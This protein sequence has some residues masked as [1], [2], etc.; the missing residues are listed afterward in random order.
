M[1]YSLNEYIISEVLV[2]NKIRGEMKIR[3]L[4][5]MLLLL[6]LVTGTVSSC[7]P[8]EQTLQIDNETSG[9]STIVNPESSALGNAN[10]S[11]LEFTDGTGK[12]IILESEPDRIVVAGKAT[13]YVLDSVYLFPSA[14]EKLVALE[15]RGFDTQAFLELVDPQVN[16]KPFLERDSGP[17]QIAPQK[18]DLVIVKDVSLAKLGSAL[19]EIGIPV[20]GVN[21]ETPDDFYKDLKA[22]GIVFNDTKRAD[23]IISFYKDKVNNVERLLEGIDESTSPKILVLQY[24]EDGGT[25]AFKV[26]PANYLQTIMIKKAGGDPV[27]EEDA[28]TSDGWM[29]VG[30]EQIASWNPDKIFVVNY[31]GDS[32]LAAAT[33]LDDP[34]W[35]GLK[36]VENK[37]IYGYPAD[38]ASWDLIDPRWVLGLEWL[39]TKIHPNETNDLNLEVEVKEFYSKLY[40]LTEAQIETEII[41][42]LE[43]LR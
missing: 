37:E 2:D 12:K 7:V 29:Q 41:P 15:V 18:P 8:V 30:L 25:I 39:A 5:S 10:A 35:Q 19:E 36:A 24:S 22:L 32:N 27:W 38:Y 23:E 6:L 21:L 3:R 13:P 43:G 40:G 4:F 9:Q 28:I 11:T 42:K 31:G 17:E 16:V 1:H 33:L 34:Q 14:A 26:P 20:M